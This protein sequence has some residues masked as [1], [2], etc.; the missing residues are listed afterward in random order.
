MNRKL[1]SVL[2]SLTSSYARVIVLDRFV[3]TFRK[4]KFYLPAT[5][6]LQE[7]WGVGI[8][9]EG[10]SVNFSNPL[11]PKFFLYLMMLKFFQDTGLQQPCAKNVIQILSFDLQYC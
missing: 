10:T 7:P 1:N 4:K 3:F 11:N 9:Q 5:W 8:C 6:F 2:L